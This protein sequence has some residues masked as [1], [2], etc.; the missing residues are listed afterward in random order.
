MFLTEQ[1]RRSHIH[2][3]EKLV[4]EAQ[5]QLEALYESIENCEPVYTS[6]P[7]SLSILCEKVLGLGPVTKENKT[8]SS[9]YV[10]ELSQCKILSSDSKEEEMKS[11]LDNGPDY[12]D[13]PE[14]SPFYNYETIEFGKNGRVEQICAICK[15][16]FPNVDTLIRHHTK[17]HPATECSFLQVEQGNDIEE[18]H[19][20]E[21]SYVGALAVTDPGLDSCSDLDS[22]K[23]TSC[24]ASFKT[25]SKL[26]VH[27][28]NCSS[29][30][31]IY[32]VHKTE[33]S[34]TKTPLKKRLQKK[35]FN[36]FGNRNDVKT[37][38]SFTHFKLSNPRN[39]I[40]S[41]KRV[42]TGCRKRTSVILPDSPQKLVCEQKVSVPT[43]SG[44]NPQNHVRRRELTE[45]LDTLTCEACGLKFKTII[46]LERH[47]KYC[48]K[49]EKFKSIQPMACPL[50][51]ESLEKIKNMCFYCTKNFTYTKS[52]LNH[53]QDFC[54]VKRAKLDRGELTEQDQI[55]EKEIIE[56]I[57]KADEEKALKQ[58]EMENRPKRNMTW[59]VGRKAKRK[60]HSWTN[61][62][63]RSHQKQQANE[64]GSTEDPEDIEGFESNESDQDVDENIA[65]ESNSLTQ[66]NLCE[67]KENV[68]DLNSSDDA[69]ER[70]KKVTENP[71]EDAYKKPENKENSSF[72]Y[73]MQNSSKNAS[74]SV[75]GENEKILD[76]FATV[77]VKESRNNA[78]AIQENVL[79]GN[80]KTAQTLQDISTTEMTKTENT[81]LSFTENDEQQSYP[82]INN[83]SLNCTARYNV[84]QVKALT[85]Y[86]P[87]AP[88]PKSSSVIF[89]CVSKKVPISRQY[90]PEVTKEY[91]KNNNITVMNNNEVKSLPYSS[92]NRS[93]PAQAKEETTF[94]QAQ[95]GLVTG[96]RK[97]ARVGKV[98]EFL[99]NAFKRKRKKIDT[100]FEK[101]TQQGNRTFVTVNPVTENTDKTEE[102]GDNTLEKLEMLDENFYPKNLYINESGKNQTEETECAAG[103]SQE[104]GPCEKTKVG[105]LKNELFIVTVDLSVKQQAAIIKKRGRGRPRGSFTKK[106]VQSK[107]NVQTP[108]KRGRPR[109]VQLSEPCAKKSEPAQPEPSLAGETVCEIIDTKENLVN[110]MQK[111][112]C[113]GKT[114]EEMDVQHSV[115]VKECLSGSDTT[116]T[117]KMSNN[118]MKGEDNLN[119]LNNLNFG[120]TD[121][122]ENCM[123]VVSSDLNKSYDHIPKQNFDGSDKSNG[124][125]I[126]LEKNKFKADTNNACIDSTEGN[127]ELSIN[128]VKSN[129]MLSESSALVNDIIGETGNNLAIQT[130][131]SDSSLDTA[132]LPT[133]NIE[134][135]NKN[136]H[137]TGIIR[138]SFD[139]V[140]GVLIATTSK[141]FENRKSSCVTNE[142]V[143][144]SSEM[145]TKNVPKNFEMV[146]SLTQ[147]MDYADNKTKGP[148]FKSQ[149]DKLE[150]I[151]ENF[152]TL[153]RSV[154]EVEEMEGKDLTGDGSFIDIKTENEILSVQKDENFKDLNFD[155]Y[156]EDE[157][158]S[159]SS[160][161]QCYLYN[162]RDAEINESNKAEHIKNDLKID[163]IES[164]TYS[165]ENREFESSESFTLFEPFLTPSERV[166]TNR[167]KCKK[168]VDLTSPVWVKRTQLNKT[169]ADRKVEICNESDD[170]IA[171]VSSEKDQR[172]S[173]KSFKS[174]GMSESL[175]S[176][177]SKLK[178][179]KRKGSEY[180]SFSS[181]TLKHSKQENV[182]GTVKTITKVKKA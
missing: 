100:D 85:K 114:I 131:I 141:K 62:K 164:K 13:A 68:N 57:Q 133:K 181:Q 98:E 5:C 71:V 104:S 175:G 138:E 8:G 31:P 47:I 173:V 60:G 89:Q 123:D 156:P 134:N 174:V 157:D 22:F 110:G 93:L 14:E 120:K 150:K 11:L 108:K 132:F 145:F 27:I 78:L 125:N 91:S 7:Q 76:S 64:I 165:E 9:H 20:S 101:S 46:I 159:V 58:K 84:N 79:P 176:D 179:T 52:L 115:N 24:N 56:R 106:P 94:Q 67:V 87:I 155:Q 168:D 167:R 90:T 151:D 59:Q 112:K 171:Q 136:Q 29:I 158:K 2:E 95:Q 88:K 130:S 107:V 53:F 21:P 16:H 61:I 119:N 72:A 121:C 180:D 6:S 25:V 30:D 41:P 109:K 42:F 3:T 126:C 153:T 127:K 35:I 113:K 86:R 96:K 118:E 142:Q 26:H 73:V 45:I 129:C 92:I 169:K 10:H 54:P 182:K 38:L 97:R 135:I 83:T 50:M 74:E 70:C 154:T 28:V 111:I 82:D 23:C 66:Q 43:V 162:E 105:D 44:Y 152:T 81:D 103:K 177:A 65:S 51:D 77:C 1:S 4:K 147:A 55:K 143:Q 99:R 18:L 122:Y 148:V 144:L 19:F 137:Q 15:R 117:N 161:D 36:M 80:M 178:G 160:N 69:T 32:G 34:P 17:K 102:I 172:T 75:D 163:Q 63:K 12:S 48:T 149:K 49:K 33:N 128:N 166:K 146:S 124:V 116:E 39:E 140:D 37:D 170:Q 139:E 40:Q